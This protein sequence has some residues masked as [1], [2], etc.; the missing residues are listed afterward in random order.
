[1]STK[2]SYLFAMSQSTVTAVARN[3]EEKHLLR[4]LGNSFTQLEE[5]YYFGSLSKT[6]T[7]YKN[8]TCY[9]NRKLSKILTNNRYKNVNCLK[10]K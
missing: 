3:A 6:M 4:C 5:L 8:I 9:N 2:L 10:P 1:M 7:N